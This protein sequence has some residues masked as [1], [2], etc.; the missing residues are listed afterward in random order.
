M[1]SLKIIALFVAGTSAA[2]NITLCSDSQ[3]NENPLSSYRLD[4]RNISQCLTHFAGK[5]LAL[6][7][8][9]WLEHEDQLVDSH[10][11]TD[12]IIASGALSR[13]DHRDDD[14]DL[15]VRFYR[16]NDC[17]GHCGSG[18]LIAQSRGGITFLSLG[19]P[20]FD[21]APGS[22]LQSF[23]VVRLD[24]NGHYGPHGY[25]GLRHGDAAFFR[26][27]HWKWQQIGDGAFREVPM[28]EWDDNE[29]PRRSGADY[30]WHGKV[31]SDGKTKLRQIMKQFWV[32]VPLEEWDDDVHVRGEDE[33][34]LDSDA[35]K[36]EIEG[37]DDEAHLGDRQYL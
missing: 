25:C 36:E 37:Q 26:G 16:S 13:N 21:P 6:K 4:E 19:R 27:Q 30:D 18:H 3:C 35:P 11:R 7:L 32:G 10:T 24:E 15:A 1:L 5:A 33:L 17:F 9:L 23:E 28:Q 22:V 31:D 34:N 12:D 20:S 29:F 14:K 8:G 2:L